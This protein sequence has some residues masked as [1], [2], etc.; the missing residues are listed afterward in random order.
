LFCRSGLRTLTN[1]YFAHPGSLHVVPEL[2]VHSSRVNAPA[3]WKPLRLDTIRLSSQLRLFFDRAFRMVNMNAQIA[4]TTYFTSNTEMIRAEVSMLRVCPNL[5]RRQMDCFLFCIK[6]R[7]EVNS[8]MPSSVNVGY[9]LTSS[10]HVPQ[11][12]GSGG[13]DRAGAKLAT[14]DK[15]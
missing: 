10:T 15:L 3:S 7:S 2:H 9:T 1:R 6:R 13:F 14:P 11:A 12:R 5:A 4:V 8:W